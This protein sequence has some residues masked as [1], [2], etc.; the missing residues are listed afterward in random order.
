M[1]RHSIVPGRG[2]ATGRAALEGRTVHIPDVL[3]DPQY[4]L[5][6]GQK[7]A[8]YRT[9]LPVPLVREGAPIGVLAMARAGP[10]P[11]TPKQI[12]LVETFADQAAIAIENVRLF[13]EILDRAS[14]WRRRASTS[15]SS[16]PA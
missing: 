11:F 3:A 15:R 5:M 10:R 9:L 12:E 6:E 4:S 14:S 8:G 13:D 16:S 7:I 1:E 2:T